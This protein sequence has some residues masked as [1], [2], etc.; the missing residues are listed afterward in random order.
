MFQFFLGAFSKMYYFKVITGA[1]RNPLSD[2]APVKFVL[3]GD[4]PHF[5]SLSK[6]IKGFDNVIMPGRTEVGCAY[7]IRDVINW[8]YTI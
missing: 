6:E 1:A 5:K 3:F 7:F 4:E 2:V 8:D